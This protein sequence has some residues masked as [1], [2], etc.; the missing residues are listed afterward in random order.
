MSTMWAAT[1]ATGGGEVLL[2]A[3]LTHQVENSGDLGKA[4][5]TAKLQ[6]A[7]EGSVGCQ[8]H[9]PPSVGCGSLPTALADRALHPLY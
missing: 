7:W 6:T 3:H 2:T 9:E 4:A 1:T 5:L 8:F